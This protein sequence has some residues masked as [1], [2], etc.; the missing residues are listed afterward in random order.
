M[1]QLEVGQK[2][3][4]AP[5]GKAYGPLSVLAQ[6]VAHVKALLR[7]GPGSFAPPPKVDSAVLL[8]EPKAGAPPPGERRA[9]LS[10]LR[11]SFAHRRKTIANNWS[12]FLAEG[13]VASICAAAGVSPKSRAEEV[14]PAA[15]VEMARLVG[16]GAF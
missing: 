3:L 4:G 6:S 9:M 8:F 16:G 1:F 2:L 7:L 13:R 10:L 5:G 12:P 14:P 11:A 15:W